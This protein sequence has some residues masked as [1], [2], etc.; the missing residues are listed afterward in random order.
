[1]KT[2]L[3]IQSYEITTGLSGA[4]TFEVH[5]AVNTPQRSISG[6]GVV[7]NNSVHPSK[8]IYT[9]LSGEFSYMTV[10]PESRHILVHLK[11]DGSPSSVMPIEMN[12]VKLTMVLESNWQKG[13]AN[14][15]YIDA[16]GNWNEI[17]DAKVTA[18]SIKELISNN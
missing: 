2:G 15:S 5:L 11:G 12:N 1:M 16:Q 9:K 8:G 14:Y 13:T 6:Q 10:M 4:P 3:F 7:S 17:K 18:V